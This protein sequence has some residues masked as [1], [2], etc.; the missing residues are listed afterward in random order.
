VEWFATLMTDMPLDEARFHGLLRDVAQ[1]SL[2]GA[3][4]PRGLKAWHSFGDA[5]RD[6]EVRDL[7]VRVLRPTEPPPSALHELQNHGFR[8]AAALEFLVL[9]QP[10]AREEAWALVALYAEQVRGW[11]LTRYLD[12]DEAANRN[13]D[14]EG[15]MHVPLN[16]G[17]GRK[18]VLLSASSLLRLAS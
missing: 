11:I 2:A 5:T 16:G 18:A 14:E 13:G 7:E 12:F 10:E 9:P 6:A 3:I 4:R 17:H 1:S 8:T 15:L